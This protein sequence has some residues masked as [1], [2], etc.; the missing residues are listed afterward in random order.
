[1]KIKRVGFIDDTCFSALGEWIQFRIVYTDG[2][3]EWVCGFIGRSLFHFFK[4]TKIVRVR[5]SYL[6]N[7]L[8]VDGEIRQNPTPFYEFFLKK[9]KK[10]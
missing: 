10:K 3:R 1:M 8:G 7:I 9:S 6:Q 4:W 5:G 2:Y